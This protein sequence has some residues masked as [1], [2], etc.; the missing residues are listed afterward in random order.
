MHT[1]IWYML[2]ATLLKSWVLKGSEMKFWKWKWAKQKNLQGRS[3]S[4]CV[5]VVV[6]IIVGENK[7]IARRAEPT[8]ITKTKPITNDNVLSFVIFLA[9][10]PTRSSQNN[11]FL[12]W[13]S[14]NNLSSV[15]PPKIWG[16]FSTIRIRSRVLVFESYHSATDAELDIANNKFK[17]KSHY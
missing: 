13:A 4:K 7:H 2:L 6:T 11:A 5:Y 1:N 14:P 10:D 8:T 3:S 9:R 15:S 16:N 17:C 12:Y